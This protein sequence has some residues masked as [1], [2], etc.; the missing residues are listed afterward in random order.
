MIAW[1]RR[2]LCKHDGPMH[3]VVSGQIAGLSF[4]K[5]SCGYCGEEI[6]YA[7]EYAGVED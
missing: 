2:K 5:W 4:E 7:D 3:H 1:I 6:F